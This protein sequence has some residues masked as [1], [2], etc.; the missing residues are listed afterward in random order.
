MLLAKKSAV[1]FTSQVRRRADAPHVQ[2]NG[3]AFSNRHHIHK[4]EVDSVLLECIF[5]IEREKS[6]NTERIECNFEEIYTYLRS[7]IEK[8]SIPRFSQSQPVFPDEQSQRQKPFSCRIFSNRFGQ[9]QLRMVARRNKA[10]I[11]CPLL[12]SLS[13]AYSGALCCDLSTQWH[14]V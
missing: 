7:F 9:L 5:T 12:Q 1:R 13:T 14:S 4:W 6:I 10:P 11:V 2:D 3:H 8:C